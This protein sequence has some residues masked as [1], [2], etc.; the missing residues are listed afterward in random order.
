[1]AGRRPTPTYLKLLKGNPGRRPIKHEP[2][3]PLPASAPE[4]PAFLS[5]YAKEEWAR[6]ANELNVLH[7]VTAI[8][9]AAFAAYCQAFARW[10][11]AEEAIARMA[12]KDPVMGGLIVKSRAGEAT[13]NPLVWVSS[14]AAKAMLRA[15]DEFGMTPAARARISGGVGPQGGG[16]PSKFG[17]LL[18]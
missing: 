13:P 11:M 10:R 9:V 6:I 7:L 8:D 16:G 3:P 1:M 4:P 2:Q 5:A 15:A 12:E 14:A 18:A 17:D